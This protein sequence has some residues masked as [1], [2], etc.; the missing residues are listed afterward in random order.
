[1]KVNFKAKFRT[2]NHTTFTMNTKSRSLRNSSYRL[3]K[4]LPNKLFICDLFFK[5]S[6]TC[7]GFI[8]WTQI[9]CINF[10]GTLYLETNVT[11]HYKLKFIVQFSNSSQVRFYYRLHYKLYSLNGIHARSRH[12]FP[13]VSQFMFIFKAVVHQTWFVIS[14]N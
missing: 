12:T 4:N 8:Y 10:V 5:C 6:Q 14:D 13:R 2:W 3:Q 1:M 9:A 11:N 7:F